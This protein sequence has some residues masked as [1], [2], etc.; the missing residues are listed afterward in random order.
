MRGIQFNTVRRII[1]RPIA[2]AVFA[3]ALTLPW[4]AHNEGKPQWIVIPLALV[5][6]AVA[7]SFWF[8][9]SKRMDAWDRGE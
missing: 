7:A 6:I 3:I 9:T 8:L 1:I 5:I 2:L 4:I